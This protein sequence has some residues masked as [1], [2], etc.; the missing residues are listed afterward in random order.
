M[1]L[2][3]VSKSTQAANHLVQDLANFNSFPVVS[4]K[5]TGEAI[6]TGNKERQNV[7]SHSASRTSTK[8]TNS[9]KSTESL[10]TSKSSVKETK[11]NRIEVTGP[12]PIKLADGAATGTAESIKRLL[13]PDAAGKIHEEE[14]QYALVV[15]LLGKAK[16]DAV[17]QFEKAFS[18]IIGSGSPPIGTE[19]A[20]KQALTKIISTGLLD[21]KLAEAI[22]GASFEAAQLDSFKALLF[23]G[24]GGPNDATMALMPIDQAVA[25]AE[26]A[27]QKMEQPDNGSLSRSLNSPSNPRMSSK[28]LSGTDS[29]VA[30]PAASGQQPSIDPKGFLW[31]PISANNGKLVVLLPK[32]LS[33]KVTEC[34]VY[35]DLPPEAENLIERG[36]FSGEANGDR[37]HYRFSHPGSYFPE[38]CYVV[39]KTKDGNEVAFEISNSSLRNSV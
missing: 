37:S 2:T 35:R 26:T 11:S 3:R 14:L 31:K 16:P 18:E 17:S 39:A 9:T 8:S 12:I 5:N 7:H 28:E 6:Q 32:S 36:K 20:T 27:L 30:K 13:T 29:T 38:K 25:K 15:H 19:D 33:G 23:D 1:E 4:K 24:T 21:L 34:A 22:N 10:S